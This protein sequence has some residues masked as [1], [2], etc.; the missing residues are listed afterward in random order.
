MSNY[1]KVI[2]KKGLRLKN[3]PGKDGYV[4]T[5]INGG[6]FG[7]IRGMHR[8]VATAFIPN[9]DNLPEVNHIDGNKINNR[10]DNLEWVTKK[11]NQY[12]ASYI[13]NKRIGED[14]WKSKL[15][16]EIVLEIY[17]LCKDKSLSYQEIA[18]L[19]NVS[20]DTPHQIASGR[21]WEH[22]KL[23]PLKRKD[24]PIVGINIETNEKITYDSVRY[25]VEDGFSASCISCCCKGK[26]KTHK[27]HTWMYQ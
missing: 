25:A 6:D 19:Y 17:E 14:C 5:S 8:I 10:V 22:L 3:S 9:P 18:E 2:N 20:S 11:E 13:L 23:K 27:G 12:H 21:T 24:K 4:H 26:L 16:D 15:N 1:G 7:M